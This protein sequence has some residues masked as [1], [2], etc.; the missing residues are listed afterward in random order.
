MSGCTAFYRDR[1]MEA[2]MP[3]DGAVQTEVSDYSPVADNLMITE[4]RDSPSELA[5]FPYPLINTNV[6]MLDDADRK[7]ATRGGDNFVLSPL[8]SARR[9]PAGRRATPISVTTAR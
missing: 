6:I 8:L 5:P 9:C 1:L 4:L 7:V 2:F 3:S